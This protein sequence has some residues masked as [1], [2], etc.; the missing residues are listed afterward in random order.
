MIRRLWSAETARHI[1]KR[2]VVEGDLVLETPACLGNGDTDEQTDMPLLVDALDTSLPLLTGASLAGALRAF[3]CDWEH[4]YERTA[5]PKSLTVRLFGG[6][7]GDDKGPQ[8]ALIVDDALGRGQR[9]ERRQEVGLDPCSRT[10]AHDRLLD[11]ELWAAGTTFPLR[12]ELL[13]CDGDDEAALCQALATALDGLTRGE[14]GLGARKRR[15]YGYCKV[16]DWRLRVFDLA[17][18]EDLLDWL[19]MGD[20]PLLS[21]QAT[22][23]ASIHEGLGV[24]QPL[25][26]RR[27]RFEI[28]GSFAIDGTLLMGGEGTADGPDKVHARASRAGHDQPRPVVPGTGLAGALR[29]RARAIANTLFPEEQA[30]RL[31]DSLFGPAKIERGTNS[32]ASPLTVAE[33]WIEGG[34]DDWVQFRTRLDRWTAGVLPGA[35]FNAQPMSGGTVALRLALRKPTDHGIGL[36]LLLLKDLWDGDL[37]LGGEIGSGRG[38][39]IGQCAHLRRRVPN[40][41]E[42]AWT[43]AADPQGG[44]RI[45]GDRQALEDY[46]SVHL[47]HW[48]DGPTSPLQQ[49]N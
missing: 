2:I 46:V 16:A 44:L 7:P 28:E 29:A 43:L 9:I 32:Y 36:I 25:A 1:R 5:D 20:E 40:Q 47:Q 17:R 14:I 13:I 34:S 23:T 35:L 19:K 33:T 30:I 31:V 26:D 12:L 4:G 42:C 11:R 21:P 38:R 27:D 10:S 18:R 39:L 24:T 48:S 15:G 37:P 6:N 49:E 41:P 3:L 8:S 22:E 45:S